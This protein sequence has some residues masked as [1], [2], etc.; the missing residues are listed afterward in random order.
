[1]K[2]FTIY[3]AG[4][5]TDIDFDTS[6]IWR[7]TA[8]EWLESRECRYR[9]HVTN[10][11]DYYNFISHTNVNENTDT[12]IYIGTY[13]SYKPSGL[14]HGQVS[15]EDKAFALAGEEYKVDI[16]T[17]AVRYLRFKINKTWG[18]A[19]YMQLMEVEFYGQPQN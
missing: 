13:E 8:K 15:D 1:M 12:W 11:N 17:P 5:I 10:P 14:P 16:T 7:A 18:N 3:L 9:V 2:D 19:N 6:N 4:Q